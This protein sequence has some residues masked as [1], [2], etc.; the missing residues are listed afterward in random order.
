[1]FNWLSIFFLLILINPSNVL[2]Q[3]QSFN[4]TASNNSYMLSDQDYIFIDLI[5]DSRIKVNIKH[6]NENIYKSK[7]FK[8]IKPRSSD[9]IL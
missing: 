4:I 3:I 5:N 9:R 6:V 1:M 2:A 8:N 7:I